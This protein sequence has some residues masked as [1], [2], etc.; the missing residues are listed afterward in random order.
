MKGPIV[1]AAAVAALAILSQ[2][3]QAHVATID[4]S[5][6]SCSYDT[7]CLTFHNTSNF[8]FTN[9]QM[10][11]KGYQG[12]NNGLDEIIPLPDILANSD[13]NVIWDQ[14]FIQP[15]V[16]FAQDYDD[17]YGGTGGVCPPGAISA[18]YC[19]LVGNFSVTFT[20]MWNGNSIF[21][22]FS[23]HVNASGGFVAW[24]GLNSIGQS[25]DPCCDVHNGTVNGTLAFIDVG[26]PDP[27]FNPNGVPEPAT[28][29]LLGLGLVALGLGRRRKIG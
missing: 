9:A 28:L 20:A 3:T 19:A 13:T 22:Q 2:S 21:S 8:D 6:D 16:L 1:S 14:N 15:G 24:E 18:F 4:G 25:E 12:L 17:E 23:P 27:G 11:L 26:I 10:E 29:S 7:P 5:Y